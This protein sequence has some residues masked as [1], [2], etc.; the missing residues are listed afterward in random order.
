MRREEYL[1]DEDES[2]RLSLQGWQSKI[3]TALPCII[4]E[5]DY[6]RYTVSAQP[7]IQGV[8]ED[9]NGLTT[10]QDL[11]LLINIPILFPSGG[12]FNITL[13]IKAGDECLVVFSARCIDAWWQSGGIQKP[14]E[15]RMHDLSDGLCILAPYSQKRAQIVKQFSNNSI[16]IRDDNNNNYIELTQDGILNIK[17]ANNLTINTGADATINVT[18][19]VNLTANS[20]TITAPINTINGT[21]TVS[22]LITGQ[23]GL[24]ISG[25]NGAQITGGLNAT[26]DIVSGDISLQGHIHGG[27]QGG[28]GTTSVPQ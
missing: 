3:W 7:A 14:Q 24:N 1:D 10:Y 28:S 17:H 21:L 2:L 26:E 11:P 9:E 25:G 22:G 23:G 13:P 8:I 19:N 16:I 4:T 6:I 12:G 20:T 5:V 27:V 15:N 18:G